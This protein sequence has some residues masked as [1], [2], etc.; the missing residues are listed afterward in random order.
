MP[1]TEQEL[2]DAINSFGSAR[3]VM[4][5]KLISYAVAEVGRLIQTLEFSPEP[6]PEEV[7]EENTEEA[8]AEAAEEP[9]VA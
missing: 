9:A 2:V 5:R 8:T 1:C 3:Q 7:E 4:D 6:E